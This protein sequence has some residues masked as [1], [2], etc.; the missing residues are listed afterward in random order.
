[1]EGLKLY[2]REWKKVAEKISTRTSAQIRNHAQKYFSKL[3]KEEVQAQMMSV[4]FVAAHTVVG[5]LNYHKS[6]HLSSAALE[7]IEKIMNDPTE[8]QREV[9]NTLR[10]LHEKYRNLQLRLESRLTKLSSNGK[11]FIS[12]TPTQSNRISVTMT[13]PASQALQSMSYMSPDHTS[14]VSPSREFGSEELIALHVLGSSLK[15]PINRPV[16]SAKIVSPQSILVENLDSDRRICGKRRI[17]DLHN[18]SDSD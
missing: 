12:L 7:K 2:G 15:M 3:S 5:S 16:N 17:E 18:I 14:N 10:A 1:L 4:N 8:V 13:G 6:S 9:E 11:Q